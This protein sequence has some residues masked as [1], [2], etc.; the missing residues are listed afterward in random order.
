MGQRLVRT[1][2]KVKQAA[3]PFALPAR[4]DLPA[5]LDAVLEAVYGAWT[6]GWDDPAGHDPRSA[7]LAAEALRLARLVVELLPDDPE[8]L[9]L[10]ALLLHLS[11]RS[12]ARRDGTAYVPLDEQDVSRWSRADLAEAERHL[13]RAQRMGRLGPYQLQAAIQSVHSRRALTGTTDWGAVAILYDGLVALAPTVGAR[14]ARAAAHRRTQGAPEALAQLAELPADRVRDYQPYWVLRSLC[15]T[16]VG[17]AEQAGQAAH[18][19]RDLTRDDAVRDHLDTLLAG[20]AA[21]P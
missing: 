2:A 9:G 8:A 12:G 16:E 21:G 5:R 19:A 4:E 11:A 3:I 10:L 14:V 15:L 1:K 7:G 6:L 18:R 17:R 20:P 13:A